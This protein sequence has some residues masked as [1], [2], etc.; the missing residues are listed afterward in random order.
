MYLEQQGSLDMQ[1]KN[2]FTKSLNTTSTLIYFS[3]V[4]IKNAYTC[5]PAYTHEHTSA[6]TC[7]HAH[8]HAHVW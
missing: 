1:K 7:M 3:G 5:K 2:F 6:Q 4:T 8:S